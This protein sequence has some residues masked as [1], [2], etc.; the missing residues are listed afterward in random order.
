ML[1]ALKRLARNS[2]FAASPECACANPKNLASREVDV[3]VARSCKILR[4]R[5]PTSRL[6]VELRGGLGKIPLIHCCFEGL[7][8]APPLY[9]N[10]RSGNSRRHCG[11]C[12]GRSFRSTREGEPGVLSMMPPSVQPPKTLPTKSWRERRKAIPSNRRTGM[13]TNIVIG[14]GL[15]ES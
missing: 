2:N 9:A 11:H 6:Y 5:Q 10:G 1:N 15:V 13:M 12:L 3:G 4:Q 7:E 14:T 8:I